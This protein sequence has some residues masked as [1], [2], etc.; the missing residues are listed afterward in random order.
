M[1]QSLEIKSEVIRLLM[2]RHIN[3]EYF[4]FY[5][6]RA[7]EVLEETLGEVPEKLHKMISDELKG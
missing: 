3:Q 4:P 2:Q 6:S 5:L 1:T 7:L